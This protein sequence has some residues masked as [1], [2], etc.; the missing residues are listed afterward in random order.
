MQVENA[1]E[2]LRWLE[3]R[4]PHVVVFAMTYDPGPQLLKDLDGFDVDF[5]ERPLKL[6][7]AAAQMERRVRKSTRGEIQNIGLPSFL[8][9]LDMD[10][11]TC[12]LEVRASGKIGRL[13]IVDGVLV[14]AEM[15]ELVGEAAAIQIIAWPR[16]RISIL[17]RRTRRRTVEQPTSYLIMESMRVVDE[18][19]LP[20]QERDDVSGGFSAP[21]QPPPAAVPAPTETPSVAQEKKALPGTIASVHIDAN[22]DFIETLGSHELL[23]EYCTLATSFFEREVLDVVVMA[24]PV[25]VMAYALP[26]S[27]RLVVLFESRAHFANARSSARRWI[28]SFSGSPTRSSASNA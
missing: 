6:N 25:S 20:T 19:D 5:L 24:S 14:H 13:G 18:S 12:V 4:Q 16:S 26:G 11:K 7:M 2:F 27:E 28:S 9:L 10:R 15:G 1:A 8:Q 17:S 23:E 22:G 21:T 3:D